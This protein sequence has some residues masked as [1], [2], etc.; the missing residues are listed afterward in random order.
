MASENDHESLFTDWLREYSAQVIKVARA[1]TWSKD[2]C[3]DLAQEILL[4]A[5]KSLPRFR[6]ESNA[7]T[8]FYRVALHTAL[9]WKRKRVSRGSREE[10]FFEFS[11]LESSAPDHAGQLEQTE[12]IERL[13]AAIHQLRST[14][15]VLV[16]MYLDE[17]SYREMAEVL[18][19][20]EGNVGVKLNR[21]KK[22]LA[23]MLNQES[24]EALSDES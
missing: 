16:L 2:E 11:R 1:Y 23:K 18:G 3:E 5:W 9:N 17:L 20:S 21:A 14:D 13:Y 12:A 7:S 19:I 6:G 22:A 24:A 4:Q 8:W 15:K 10:N